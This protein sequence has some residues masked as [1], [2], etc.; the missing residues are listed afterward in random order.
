MGCPIVEGLW[1]RLVGPAAAMAPAISS[2]SSAKGTR[3]DCPARA[4]SVR[5]AAAKK[6]QPTDVLWVMQAN[7]RRGTASLQCNAAIDRVV[8]VFQQLRIESNLV[9]RLAIGGGRSGGRHLAQTGLCNLPGAAAIRQAVTAAKAAATSSSGSRE[10]RHTSTGRRALEDSTAAMPQ[11]K[12][13][14][15]APAPARGSVA[16]QPLQNRRQGRTPPTGRA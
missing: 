6:P 15:P 2:G 16:P 5:T 4:P 14:A 10:Q 1:S 7:C 12:G 3:A 9:K 13:P 8:D 11:S